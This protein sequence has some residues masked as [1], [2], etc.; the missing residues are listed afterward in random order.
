MRIPDPSSLYRTLVEKMHEVVWMCDEQERTVYVNPR[1]FEMTGF[2]LDD[3]IGKQSYDF[4]DPESAETVRKVNSNERVRGL[5]S[6]YEGNIITKAGEKIPVFVSGMPL[7]SGGTMGIMTDMRE[8]KT[9]EA[10]E[11][12]LS[13]A[14]QL[15]SDAIITLSDDGT[16]LSWNKGARMTFGYRETE[17]ISK[18]IDAI[19]APEDLQVIL[20]PSGAQYQCEL[21]AKHKQKHLVTVSAT[22][23]PVFADPKEHRH[24][25]LLIAHDITTQKKVEEEL[26]LKYTKLRDAYNTFGILRRHMDYILELAE[27]S[28]QPHSLKLI[29]DFIV[30]AVIMLTRVD[31][32]SL[33]ILH[34]DGKTLNAISS[35]GLSDDWLGKKIIRYQDSMTRRAFEQ[36]SALKIIDLTKESRYHSRA[37]AKKSNL[38]SLL[39][40]PLV[41]QKQLLGSISLYAGPEKKLEILENEF[42]E[43]FAHVV[44][45]VLAAYREPLQDKAA[46]PEKVKKSDK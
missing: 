14:I 6:S 45:L 21:H 40:I 42:I 1:F 8:V 10:Q 12:V 31:A 9:R 18:S 13:R 27:L 17:I 44:T 36:G 38:H 43:R 29:T 37:L 25:L 30:N 39:V 34:K 32:C 2:T 15:A 24:S 5:S 22:V 20:H 19:I 11:R 26:A 4:W 3:I 28:S 33:R 46:R 35:F 16:V 23:T 41:F 7:E